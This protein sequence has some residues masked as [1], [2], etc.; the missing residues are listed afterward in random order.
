MKVVILAGGRGT[1]LGEETNARPKAMVGVG[2]YPILWHVMKIYSHYGFNDFVILTGY[3]QETIKNYFVNY[4]MNNS[5]VTV[6]LSNNSIEVHQTM[7]EPWK[8]TLFYTG[9]NTKTGGRIKKVKDFIGNEPFL[10]TYGNGISDAN[11]S[12]LVRFHKEEG[13]LCTLTAIQ[14]DERFGLL[15]V[16]NDMLVSNFQEK[17]QNEETWAN[18]GFFV[19]DSEVFDYIPEGDDI[20]WEEIPLKT[21]AKAGQLNAFKHHGFGHSIETLKDKEH[22]NKIWSS[23]DV[24]WKVWND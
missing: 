17:Y 6:D 14:P 19:C 15:K 16:E 18:G 3:K 13:K 12:D 22:L 10:L 23:G 1:K 20:A 24:P 11:I 2:G 9:R 21:L 7:C 4:Y 5:N 8:V